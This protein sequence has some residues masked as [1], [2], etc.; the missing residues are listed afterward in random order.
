MKKLSEKL[1][2]NSIA[3]RAVL[4]PSCPRPSGLTGVALPVMRYI[5]EAVCS[6]EII[7]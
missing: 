7:L 3:G 5:T 4:V 2:K 6:V 1:K